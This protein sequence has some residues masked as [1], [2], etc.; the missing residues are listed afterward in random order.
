MAK[1]QRYTVVV[2]VDLPCYTFNAPSEEEAIGRAQE[3]ILSA[4]IKP[5]TGHTVKFQLWSVSDAEQL[6]EHHYSSLDDIH[7]IGGYIE[8]EFDPR[9][10]HIQQIEH[11]IV[12][13]EIVGPTHIPCFKIRGEIVPAAGSE[14]V[15][16]PY[17]S[18]VHRRGSDVVDIPAVRDY[19]AC[20]DC[21]GRLTWRRSTIKLSGR[22]CEYCGS[23]FTDERYLRPY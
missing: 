5:K 13:K 23:L 1:R 14:D 10:V 6:G 15:S 16:L 11:R 20:P 7:D 21:N 17:Y 3:W 22:V 9:P 19:P 4:D 2:S 8:R 18:E 12:R